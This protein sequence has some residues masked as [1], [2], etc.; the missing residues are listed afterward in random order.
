MY[1]FILNKKASS[2]VGRKVWKKLKP[3]L[4]ENSV[5]YGDEH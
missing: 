3:I 5:D 2:G 1:H 4:T